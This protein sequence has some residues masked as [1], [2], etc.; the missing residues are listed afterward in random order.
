MVDVILDERF[1]GVGD[2]FFDGLEL[3]G[4]VE[5]RAAG[6][7]H[8]RDAPKVTFR[9]AQPLDDLRMSLVDSLIGHGDFFPT[10]LDAFHTLTLGAHCQRV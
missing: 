5:A 8:D 2:G 1:L 6:L 10:S 4:D 3:L 7:K 9:A